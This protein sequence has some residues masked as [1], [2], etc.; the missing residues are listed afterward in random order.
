MIRFLWSIA[1]SLVSAAIAFLVTAL[2]VKDFHLSW[3]GFIVGVLV[4][5]AAQA[6]LSPFVFN[7][8]RKYA[9][10]VLGGVG[11]ISTLLSLWVASLFSDG[12][13]IDG[14][15][16]WVLSALI[17]WLITALGSWILLWLIAKKYVSARKSN[18]DPLDGLV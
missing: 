10:P 11:I 7:M 8:A 5:V 18:K 14:V 6:L 4:F 13:R 15:G 17:V 12:L 16:T 2:I 1:V 3:G 9:S